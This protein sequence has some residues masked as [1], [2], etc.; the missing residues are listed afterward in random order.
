MF[1][2][3]EDHQINLEMLQSNQSAGSFLDEISKWQTT[4][5]HI[6]SILKQWKLVQQ[7]WIELDYLQQFTHFDPQTNQIFFKVDRDFRALMISVKNNNNVLK[8]CQK[9]SWFPLS[10]IVNG[11]SLFVSSSD[12]LSMLKYLKKQLM[13]C[14]ETLRKQLYVEHRRGRL[15]FLTD[16]QLFQLITSGFI[17]S[18]Q[19]HWRNEERDEFRM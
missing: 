18:D 12:L 10:L 3:I 8:S 14:E 1:E 4:L 7:Y 9:K 6:E 2:E 11:K 16:L 19:I 15:A 17:S 5:Q 13:K